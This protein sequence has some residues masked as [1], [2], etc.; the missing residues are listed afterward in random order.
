M[1]SIDANVTETLIER[2]FDAALIPDDSTDR[3]PKVVVNLLR[4]QRSAV[5]L[6]FD[7]VVQRRDLSL[8]FVK[9]A[10]PQA[11]VAFDLG[12]S[13]GKDTPPCA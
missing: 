2:G 10:Y 7:V 11:V 4:D 12:E 13:V 3:D 6:V 1:Y 8:S 9:E 5:D